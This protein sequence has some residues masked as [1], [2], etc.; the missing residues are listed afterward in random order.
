MWNRYTVSITWSL[1][2]WKAEAA[3]G[4]AQFHMQGLL[5]APHPT[6]PHPL[7]VSKD[8]A[9][10]SHHEVDD[11]EILLQPVAHKLDTHIDEEAQLQ[12]GGFESGE[13][14]RG[15]LGIQVSRFD[16]RV[17]RQVI[18][19]LWGQSTWCQAGTGRGSHGICTLPV[20]PDVPG[21]VLPLSQVI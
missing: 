10:R 5:W 16:P 2:T 4:G 14:L 13:V 1:G 18:H 12:V 11:T 8:G 17:L 21:R 9:Q 6:P 19:H 7:W 15:D 20:P 3:A